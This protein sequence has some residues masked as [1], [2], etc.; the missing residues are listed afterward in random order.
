M[1]VSAENL[2]IPQPATRPPYLDRTCDFR[3]IYVS[4]K[5]RRQ[6]GSGGPKGSAALASKRGR[7]SVG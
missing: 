5:P 4:G 1:L 2:P 3:E 6:T 7:S